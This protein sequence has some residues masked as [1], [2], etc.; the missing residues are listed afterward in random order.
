MLEALVQA[1][2]QRLLDTRRNVYFYHHVHASGD[3]NKPGPRQRPR[4][5]GRRRERRALSKRN[6]LMTL[7]RTGQFVMPA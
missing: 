6:F 2:F 3:P 1:L 5:P 7:A 4:K